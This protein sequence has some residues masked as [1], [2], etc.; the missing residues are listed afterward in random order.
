MRVLID[1]N[2]LVRLAAGPKDPS[3][4]VA[5]QALAVLHAS[6]YSVVIV[7]QVVYEFWVVATRPLQANG[8]QMTTAAVDAFLQ[9]LERLGFSLLLDERAIYERWLE[10]VTKH[11]VSGKPSHDAR[12]VAA[13]Q[14]HGV[15]HLLTFNAGDFKRFDGLSVLDPPSVV[16]GGVPKIPPS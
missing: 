16:A 14:R 6:R 12:L 9:H 10:L 8:L 4:E 3:F 7:P 13:M 11:R 5:E 1:T 2:L 15:N